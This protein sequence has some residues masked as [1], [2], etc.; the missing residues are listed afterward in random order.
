ME[1]E[2]II[3]LFFQREESALEQVREKYGGLCR[4]IAGKILNDGR[5]IEECVV[6]T[7]LRLWRSIP[8]QKPDSL[9]AYTARITRNLALDRYAYNTAAQRSTALT[10]AFEEL[11]QDLGA[12]ADRADALREKEFHDLLNRFLKQQ[13]QKARIFFVRR[14]WY[15]ESAGE[16]ARDCGCSEEAVKSS[17]F[18][19]RTKLRKMLEEE[20][21]KV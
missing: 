3:T 2:K 20:G 11:E 4:T 1:D 21:V 19:T 16:I 6:D 8:P 9:K 18:R 17:L 12:A 13:K 10:E 7:W 15:G 5:D 14:Y